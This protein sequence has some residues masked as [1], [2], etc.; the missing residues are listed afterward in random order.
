MVDLRRLIRAIGPAEAD[1][2]V[3]LL[4]VDFAQVVLGHQPEQ[5][6][7]RLHLLVRHVTCFC[8][9]VNLA[10]PARERR[11]SQANG[12]GIARLDAIGV[13][14]VGSTPEALAAHLAAESARWTKLIAARGI[15]ID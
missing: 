9:V 4:Q 7:D 12:Y 5:V 10:Q 11:R 1:A 8:R 14:S 13:E 15:K 2:L 3:G 6:L